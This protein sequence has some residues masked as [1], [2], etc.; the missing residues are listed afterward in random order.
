MSQPR[1]L[2][3]RLD[4]GSLR[5]QTLPALLGL[6]RAA[7]SSGVASVT[8]SDRLTGGPT[9]LD[10]LIAASALAPVTTSIGLIPEVVSGITE[11]FHTATAI[12]TIDH[13]SLGRAGLGLR[14]GL[15]R[16]EHATQGR[17]PATDI[18]TAA[19]Y[20]DA[21]DTS[22][23]SPGSGS[24]GSQTP[25]SATAPPTASWTAPAFTTRPSPAIAS[26]SR[27]PPSPPAP[28]RAAR[29]S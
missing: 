25:S 12:Q 15:D 8:L 19:I 10:A 22:R 3:L 17:W 5:A 7:E 6:V 13:A 1:T 21:D 29:R 11:P 18:T 2:N 23:P 20:A 16:D 28:R 4:T 27:V 26:A 14:P 24:R 9:R